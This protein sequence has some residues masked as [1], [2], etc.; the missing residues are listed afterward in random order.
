MIS[1]LKSLDPKTW[2]AVLEQASAGN[3]KAINA[4]F[5]G[6]D[7]NVFKLIN[8][9]NS[10]KE[11]WRILKIAYESTKNKAR[12][13]AQGYS[14]VESFDFDETFASIT[15][16]E[17]IRLLLGISC[18]RRFKLYHMDVK[19][20]FLNGSMIG[21]L[22]YLAASMPDITFDTGVCA[23]F[24]SDPKG[25]HLAAL[26]IA[27]RI[28]Q[29]VRRTERVL[30]EDVSFLE[31]IWF[32]LQLADIFTKPLDVSSFKH[33]RA[34]LGFKSTP[35]QC[36]Y[37]LSFERNQIPSFDPTKESLLPDPIDFT[38]PENAGRQEFNEFDMDSDEKDDVSLSHLLKHEVFGKNTQP[39]SG[40]PSASNA[41]PSGQSVSLSNTSQIDVPASNKPYHSGDNFSQGSDNV[42]QESNPAHVEPK[43][44]S[45]SDNRAHEQSTKVHEPN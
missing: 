28:E 12:L 18:I 26:V 8:S 27:I 16:L 25:T 2:R 42:D 20:A 23:R 19:S 3:S 17:A 38:V 5:N 7:L 45:T 35:L 21:G 10:A 41:V 43:S 36:P 37:R 32:S 40:F 31:I 1:F 14:Q 13:V 29:D 39:E 34:G 33:L 4:I 30:Q 44:F 9:Y 22:L 15:R 6:V 11:A 24:Q